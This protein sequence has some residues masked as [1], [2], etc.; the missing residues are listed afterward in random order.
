MCFVE[1]PKIALVKQR[2]EAPTIENIDSY[3]EEELAEIK[4]SEKVQKGMSIAIT[5]G[6][7]GIA[8]IDKIIAVLVKELKRLG[9]S[10][11]IVPTMGSH[12]GATAMGQEEVLH[13]LGITEFNV[14]APVRSSMDVV[15][16]DTL[17]SGMPVYIDKHAYEADGIILVGRIKP[18]TDFKAPIESGLLK[19]AAIGL[20]K[21]AQAL[22]LHGHGIHGIRDLMPDVGKKIIEKSNILFGLGIIEN[23]FEKTAHIVAIEKEMIEAKEKELLL[24]AKSYMPRLPVEDIDLLVVDEIGKNYTGTGM[25]TNII[26][27]IRIEG[28][29]EPISPRIKYILASDVSE[30][31]HGNALGIG[32]ADLT[33]KRLFEKIDFKSMNENVITSTFLNRAKIP[34]VLE[35]DYEAIKAAL[36]ANWGIP[37]QE[38]RIIRIPSTLHIEYLYVSEVILSEIEDQVEII[39]P[40]R[41]MQFDSDGYFVKMED[42]HETNMEL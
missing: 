20:G 10:P 1:L 23:A 27:R 33:T 29:T 37:S 3:M 4:L 34:M 32:L 38:A 17:A 16:L 12:G 6:S 8:N 24:I 36:R 28:V 41:E 19:M 39:E 26:G 15:Q 22:A 30:A 7:R 40:L 42:E 9:A 5:A 31:S 14:G 21:H 18:H 13:S 11:F 25:D 35:N 2:F